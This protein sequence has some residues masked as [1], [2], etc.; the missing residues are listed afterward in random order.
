MAM[1]PEYAAALA[2]VEADEANEALARQL[3]A[4]DEANEALAPGLPARI[5][6]AAVAAGYPRWQTPLG[7]AAPGQMP[8]GQM[9]PMPM[10]LAQMPMG[11]KMTGRSDKP[12]ERMRTT[13]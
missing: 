1:D 9:M 13:E 8:P 4:A 6:R 2:V 7:W 10:G 12:W 11:L 5:V 3:L